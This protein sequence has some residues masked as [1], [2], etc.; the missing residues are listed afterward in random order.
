MMLMMAVLPRIV[1]A[2]ARGLSNPTRSDFH[3]APRSSLCG[4]KSCVLPI[5]DVMKSGLFASLFKLAFCRGKTEG[6]P[7]V[8]DEMVHQCGRPPRASQEREV[9]TVQELV[10]VRVLVPVCRAES[11]PQAG[12]L[13]GSTA[14][15]MTKVTWYVF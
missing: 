15:A 13:A 10:H 12:A 1:S 4:G 6:L 7:S 3:A 9:R 8:C 11:R 2:A 14:R 5:D